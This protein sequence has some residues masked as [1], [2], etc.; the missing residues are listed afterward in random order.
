M[1]DEN[2][3][4]PG[5]VRSFFRLL[6]TISHLHIKA[7]TF[8]FTYLLLLLSALCKS[9]EIFI[10][11]FSILCKFNFFVVVCLFWESNSLNCSDPT[12]HLQHFAHVVLSF[13]PLFASASSHHCLLFYHS[14]P[15][16]LLCALS[17]RQ[18]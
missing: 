13:S 6:A 4:S 1:T 18:L 10:F 3:F 7:F 15:P 2:H 5:F 11:K 17:V 14:H 9:I 8:A 12:S 16:P